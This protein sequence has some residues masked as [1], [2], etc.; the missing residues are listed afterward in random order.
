M[1]DNVNDNIANFPVYPYEI[2]RD[3][4]GYLVMRNTALVNEVILRKERIARAALNA[5]ENLVQ[6]A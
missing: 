1:Y 3:R 4:A 2:I 5:P 6:A